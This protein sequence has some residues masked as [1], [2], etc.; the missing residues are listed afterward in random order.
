MYLHDDIHTYIY[1]HLT[2][3]IK[4]RQRKYSG[5]RETRTPDLNTAVEKKTQV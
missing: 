5:G 1:T 4:R 3:T 2:C